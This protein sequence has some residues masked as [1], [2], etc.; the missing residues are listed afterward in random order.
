MAK[1]YNIKTVDG[2]RFEFVT[3][4]DISNRLGGFLAIELERETKY[5]NLSNIVIVTEREAEGD[6]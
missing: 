4:T 5:F 1:K 3:N 6:S 2:S